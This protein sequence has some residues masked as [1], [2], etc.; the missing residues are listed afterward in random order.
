MTAQAM[1]EPKRRRLQRRSTGAAENRDRAKAR[2][3]IGK[4]RTADFT[5]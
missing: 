4:A 5:G 1:I 3:I 2:V